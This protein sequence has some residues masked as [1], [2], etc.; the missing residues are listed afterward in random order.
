MKESFSSLRAGAVT[1]FEVPNLGAF[2]FLV[3]ASLG[4]VGAVLCGVHA[5][6]KALGRTM[7]EME[8]SAKE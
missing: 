2:N 4:K 7:L 3:A 5:Q 1:R 8:I 6:G